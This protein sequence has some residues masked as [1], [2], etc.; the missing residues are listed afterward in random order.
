MFKKQSIKKKI[1]WFF[2]KKKFIE[3]LNDCEIIITLSTYIL[4]YLKKK[5]DIYENDIKMIKQFGLGAKP[6]T[7]EGKT[8]LLLETFA[9]IIKPNIF[10]SL[11]V[12]DWTDAKKCALIVV[13]EII[14]INAESF[15]D[16]DNNTIVAKY[17]VF[18]YKT[19][20]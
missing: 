5:K 11:I 6:Q 7:I 18:V 8:K 2:K 9:E 20:K 10:G 16:F 14:S 3:S 13:D 15:K 4:N 19:S 12:R 1:W 17:S